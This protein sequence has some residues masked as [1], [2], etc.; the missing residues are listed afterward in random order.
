MTRT[1]PYRLT[2]VFLIASLGGAGTALADVRTQNAKLAA[3]IDDAAG[4]SQTFG[5]LLASVDAANGIVYI[6][7]GRCDRVRACLLHKMTVAGSQRVLTVVIDPARSAP[8]LAGVI[9]HELQ[10][11]VEVLSDERTT[12]DTDVF[13]FYRTRGLS[14]RGWF[15][16]RAAVEKADAV[17]REL[18]R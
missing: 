11:A 13:A 5:R 17:R 14:A 18:R 1:H 15:E 2:A 8:E 6:T 4:R 3:L 7:P 10:H 12:S 9:A 16:T